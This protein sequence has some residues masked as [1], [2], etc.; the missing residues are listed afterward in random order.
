MDINQSNTLSLKGSRDDND[1][2][3]ICP[4]QLDVIERA[5]QLW[6]N[7]NDIVFTPFLGIGSEVYQALKMRRRGIG[8]EL[9]PSYFNVARKNCELA[10]RER[11]EQSL[12]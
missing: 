10:L 3:H 5:L 12:F 4:L 1:E 11:G 2:K 8:I 6:S 9:K 7:E